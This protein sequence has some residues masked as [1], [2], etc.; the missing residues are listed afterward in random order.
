MQLRLQPSMTN[1]SGHNGRRVYF[2]HLAACDGWLTVRAGSR[3]SAVEFAEQHLQRL[4]VAGGVG[5][6][7]Q[8]APGYPGWEFDA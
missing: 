4:G 1:A 7:E 5:L 8:A 2:C 3:Q 6:V